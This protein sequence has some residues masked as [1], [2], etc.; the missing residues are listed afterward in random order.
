MENLLCL[1]WFGF[2]ATFLQFL[3]WFSI[4][5]CGCLA[6]AVPLGRERSPPQ[7]SRPPP[8][9]PRP[10]PVLIGSVTSCP[11]LQN[12]FFGAWGWLIRTIESLVRILWW[13]WCSALCL[14]I[15]VYSAPLYVDLQVPFS[16][17]QVGQSHPGTSAV[18]EVTSHI[19][20]NEMDIN[21]D[22]KCKD[23][24]FAGA[25]HTENPMFSALDELVARRNTNFNGSQ[26]K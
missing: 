15:L 3:L 4:W 23:N 16:Y 24:I 12:Q 18:L 21:W 11:P 19:L 20:P 6:A 25:N 17:A 14:A 5:N 9:Y 26:E 22:Q 13:N 1:N 10:S 8:P 7:S 2:V